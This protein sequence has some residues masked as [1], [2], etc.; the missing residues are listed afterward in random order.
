MWCI[1]DPCHPVLIQRGLRPGAERHRSCREGRDRNKC[2]AQQVWGP[3][4]FWVGGVR[5]EDAEGQVLMLRCPTGTRAPISAG[6]ALW[7]WMPWR[8]PHHLLL[9]SA[10][11]PGSGKAHLP[12]SSSIPTRSAQ[13]TVKPCSLTAGAWQGWKAGR[14]LQVGTTPPAP[15]PWFQW[16]TREHSDRGWGAEVLEG[17]RQ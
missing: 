13:Q 15:E 10:P 8:S 2:P 9:R 7:V 5:N 17:K 1:S 12:L 16:G 3:H 4:G 11:L 6:P 14:G